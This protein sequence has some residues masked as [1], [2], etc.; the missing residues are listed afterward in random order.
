[1]SIVERFDLTAE[2]VAR[3]LGVSARRVRQIEAGELPYLQLGEH[4]PRRYRSTDVERYLLDRI[5]GRTA[6]LRDA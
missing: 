6:E 2:D 1:M 4:G 5:R 3:K